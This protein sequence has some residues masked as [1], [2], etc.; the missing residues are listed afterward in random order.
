MLSAYPGAYDLKTDDVGPPEED[1]LVA[2][3]G[4]GRQPGE[5]STP[6]DQSALFA[7]YHRMFRTAANPP[8]TS[9]ALSK[10]S[11]EQLLA[12]LPPVMS[13]LVNA[14]RSRLSELPGVKP[15]QWCRPTA[16]PWSR[17]P[18]IA[19]REQERS[20]AVTAG[21]GSG[22]TELL[23][24]RAD[25]LL[26]TNICPYPRR[27]LAIS[28][29][30]DAAANLG[31]GSASASSQT[32]PARLD[33]QTFH[34]FSLRLIRRFRPVLTGRDQLDPGFTIGR[35]PRS[36]HADHLRGFRPPRDPDPRRQPARPGRAA[37]HLQSR[38]PGRV[39]GLHQEPVRL[40][41][42]AFLGT[43]IILTAVGDTKQRIMG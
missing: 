26:Q 18:T 14:V 20:V 4:K 19:C 23:A 6:P 32:W 22:K 10:L 25:L 36:P 27:I 29:K 1:T 28:F 7:E 39:P 24:Q 35:G 16:S 17:T 11:D 13:R 2:V 31:A 21:P 42:Q 37:G 38:V 30:A 43:G 33:S 12:A 40:I 34:G 9:A 8:S 15:E 3:L 5:S 41:R